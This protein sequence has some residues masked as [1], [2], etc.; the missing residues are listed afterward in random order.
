M[1]SVVKS[2]KAKFSYTERTSS[3]LY[4]SFPLRHSPLIVILTTPLNPTQVS[5][6]LFLRFNV[7]RG[8]SLSTPP[9]SEHKVRPI[10]S[11]SSHLPLS[12]PFAHLPSHKHPILT[13]SNFSFSNLSS[14]FI[15]RKNA[16]SRKDK[17]GPQW[18]TWVT[19]TLKKLVRPL[20]PS[21][22]HR[23]LA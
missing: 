10:N 14:L 15:V 2:K 7:I 13:L 23:H 18:S 20:L 3:R 21:S 19:R 4:P 22:P 17:L 11:T 6:M 5:S 9:P 8:S 16:E 1:V 12:R